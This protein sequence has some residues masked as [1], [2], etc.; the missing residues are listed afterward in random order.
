M[1]TAMGWRGVAA[2]CWV[3]A[4]AC[5]VMGSAC[6]QDASNGTASASVNGSAS[7]AGAPMLASEIGHSTH[8][9]L[10][11]QRSGAAAAP[12]LPMLGEEAGLAYQR[13]MDSFR[14][15]IPASFGSSLNG[16]GNMLHVDYTNVGGA[17]QN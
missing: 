17:S 3:T 16:N 2:A 9:W 13:Y 4:A 1:K 12:A 7:S 11:L 5:C 6:A 14:T 15:K 8:D 10:D